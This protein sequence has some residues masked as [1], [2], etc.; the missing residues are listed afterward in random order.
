MAT[1][2]TYPFDCWMGL[3][4]AG[5]EV[6]GAGYRRRPAHFEDIGD[7]VTGA[8]A[9]SVQW[10]AC[11]GAWGLIDTVNLYDALTGGSVICTGA[12][13]SA[14]QGNMYDELRVSAGTYAVALTPYG[15]MMAGGGIGSPY[16]VGGY[17]VGPYE[18]LSLT[19][20]LLRTFGTVALCGN[21]PGDWLPTPP[22]ETGVWVPPGTCEAGT[23]APGPFD[24]VQVS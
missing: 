7:G 19:V 20:L 14:V 5:S 10:P 4:V 11:G 18:T 6:T 22:C 23:W 17:G 15:L 16:D 21:Q 9:A 1:G 3:A 12:A 13:T 24:V 2:I 8:N